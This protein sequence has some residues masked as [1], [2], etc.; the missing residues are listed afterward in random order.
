MRNFYI[1]VMASFSMIIPATAGASFIVPEEQLP[2]GIVSVSPAQGL[3][4]L[5]GDQS[6]LGVQE[7][8]VMFDSQPENNPSAS[9]SFRLLDYDTKNVLAELPVKNPDGG[10][11]SYIDA[12]G[13]PSAGLKFP[14]GAYNYLREGRYQVVLPAG[15]W[16]VGG[17]PSP[18]IKANYQIFET[19]SVTPAA[20]KVEQLQNWTVEFPQ[21]VS[22]ELNPTVDTSSLML[23]SFTSVDGENEWMP[24]IELEGLRARF[25]L[26]FS[27]E[28]MATFTLEIPKGLF[29]VTYA[30][31]TTLQSEARRIV[32]NVVPAGVDAMFTL[33]PAPGTVENFYKFT[34]NLPEGATG[35]SDTMCR[36]SAIYRLNADDSLG[37]KICALSASFGFNSSFE[38]TV[39][40]N[41]GVPYDA[42][43]NPGNGNYRLVI[44]SGQW[45][46]SLVEGSPVANNPEMTYDY[47]IG[48]KSGV[49]SVAANVE[50]AA[51]YDFQGRM[52]TGEPDK[53][54]FIKVVDGKAVKMVK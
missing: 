4:N 42:P 12:M 16:L 24:L 6:P 15:A 40:A 17:N 21:A 48:E 14:D 9:G 8:S 51:Y 36:K 30:D 11:N 45:T 38:L 13:V 3:V 5:I 23:W 39:S 27:V 31:G 50:D 20:G 46:G 7:I 41:N 34:V 43:I 1:G 49:Q 28:T 26:P 53:G 18:E 54:I 22:V 19:M 25:M 37:E 35:M 47:T 29:I 32:Y 10:F 33:D 52:V 44:A 2:E